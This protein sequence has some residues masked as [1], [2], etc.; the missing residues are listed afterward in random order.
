MEPELALI[1]NCQNCVDMPATW[2]RRLSQL[3][4]AG[5]SQVNDQKAFVVQPQYDIFTSAID[6]FYALAD[7]PPAKN[8]RRHT[9]NGCR[10]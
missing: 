8:V 1:I 9:G 7:D 10:P 6:P 5:H 4:S 3:K 2:D